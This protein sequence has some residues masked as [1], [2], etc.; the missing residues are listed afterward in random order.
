M[1]YEGLL[2]NTVKGFA[3][4]ASVAAIAG[5]PWWFILLALIGVIYLINTVFST[6]VNLV[7]LLAYIYG[8]FKWLYTSLESQ[9]KRKE[10]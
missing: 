10:Q 1:A 9:F 3:Q 8:F 5:V 4:A 7:Y 2:N 6:G